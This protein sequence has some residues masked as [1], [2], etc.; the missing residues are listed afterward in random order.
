MQH[1][2]MRQ[3][4]GAPPQRHREGQRQREVGQGPPRRAAVVEDLGQRRVLQREE[5]GRHSRREPRSTAQRLQPGARMSGAGGELRDRHAD[6]EQG[7]AQHR[8]PVRQRPEQDVD[9]GVRVAM[10]QCGECMARS[11]PAADSASAMS[12]CAT[13]KPT[14]RSETPPGPRPSEMPGLPRQGDAWPGVDGVCRRS[15][16]RVTN[17][18]TPVRHRAVDSTRRARCAR[19]PLRPARRPGRDPACIGLT[20]TT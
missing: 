3:Q 1:D 6:R 5:P 8:G 18:P 12:A 13:A 16:R 19:R 10:E 20:S 15:S 11:R 2:E 7:N 4:P 14:R 9:R 17:G